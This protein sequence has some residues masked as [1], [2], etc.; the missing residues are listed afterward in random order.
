ML[1]ANVRALVVED[2]PA[3]AKLLALVLRDEGCDVTVAAS[4]EAALVALETSIPHIIV[5]DLV[6]PLMSGLLLA[7]QLRARPDTAKVPII[8]VSAFNGNEVERAALAAGCA[9]YIRKP[10]DALS[11][12]Q[13]LRAYLGGIR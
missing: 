3:S 9:V 6:L 11:F 10:I 4:A 2:D 1:L 7:Q 12:P 5:L 13:F 8:A